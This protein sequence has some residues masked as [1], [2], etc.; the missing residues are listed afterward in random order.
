M[1]FQL[2]FG[3][4]NSGEPPKV[5]F[6]GAIVLSVQWQCD[7]PLQLD[8]SPMSQYVWYVP[9]YLHNRLTMVDVTEINSMPCG[10][11]SVI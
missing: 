9:S 1:L 4:S 11:E 7:T 5:K 8:A 10:G 2:I 3:S 6:N